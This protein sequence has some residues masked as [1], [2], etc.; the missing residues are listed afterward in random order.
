MSAQAKATLQR[1][2]LLAALDTLKGFSRHQEEPSG[3][4]KRS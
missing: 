2:V 3:S 4:D 1:A